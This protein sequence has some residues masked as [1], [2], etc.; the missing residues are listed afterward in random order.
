[1][2]QRWNF[3][4]FTP[5]RGLYPAYIWIFHRSA[6]ALLRVT[7]SS[8]PRC[9]ANRSQVGKLSFHSTDPRSE[10]NEQAKTGMSDGVEVARNGDRAGSR[11][12]AA[13]DSNG[14]SFASADLRLQG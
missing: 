7:T 1:V 13:A 14:D 4:S 5:F 6:F 8:Q 3:A 11:V 12:F 2:P 10:L 9:A